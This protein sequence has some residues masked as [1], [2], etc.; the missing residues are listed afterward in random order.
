MKKFA[1]IIMHSITHAELKGLR[2]KEGE[3]L[4]DYYR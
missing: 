4:R 1:G 3:S 2:Q